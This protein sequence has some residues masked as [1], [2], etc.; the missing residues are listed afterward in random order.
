MIFNAN[1]NELLEMIEQKIAAIDEQCAIIS[2]E[3]SMYSQE[4]LDDLTLLA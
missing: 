2:R 3:I 4:R 1:K